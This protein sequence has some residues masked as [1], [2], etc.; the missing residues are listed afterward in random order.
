[1][2]KL[3][4]WAKQSVNESLRVEKLFH[5][6][7]ENQQESAMNNKRLYNQQWGTTWSAVQWT[8]FVVDGESEVT[9]GYF[10]V[11]KD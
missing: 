1:M 11:K 10:K 6:L 5:Q 9:R 4:A 8:W 2:N 7:T 3:K